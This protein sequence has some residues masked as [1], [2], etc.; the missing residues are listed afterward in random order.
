MKFEEFRKYAKEYIDTLAEIYKLVNYKKPPAN[1]IQ[2]LQTKAAEVLGQIDHILDIY[3]TRRMQFGEHNR[4]VD[5]FKESL[6]ITSTWGSAIIND[7]IAEMR[8]VTAKLS[9]L[10]S[11]NPHLEL[12]E[13]SGIQIEANIPVVPMQFGSSVEQ[14]VKKLLSIFP[15]EKNVFIMMP[16]GVSFKK[17][18]AR[19]LEE[20][21]SIIETTLR[22][23]YSLNVLR[24]DFRDFSRSGWLW[25][26]VCVYMLASKYGIAVLENFCEEK[27]N[28]NVAMEFG[29]MQALGRECLLLK[30]KDFRNVRADILGRLWIEFDSSSET[31]MRKTVEEAIHKWL[32]GKATRIL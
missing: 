24:A 1:K 4:E 9:R 30:D 21:F 6:T 23:C 28:P 15:F 3:A 7:A 26:N 32:L 13:I 29:F 16:F 19:K 31:S 22:R 17:D 27:F 2:K 11:L 18:C 25:N 12:P 10:Y 20:L 5:K 14:G 8:I